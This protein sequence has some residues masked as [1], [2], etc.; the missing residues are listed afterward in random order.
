MP[1]SSVPSAAPV[2]NLRRILPVLLEKFDRTV[3]ISALSVKAACLPGAGCREQRLEAFLD[4]VSC[5]EAEK[6]RLDHLLAVTDDEKGK[7]EEKRAV[8]RVQRKLDRDEEILRH[9]N[10]VEALLAEEEDDSDCG[11]TVL[12][13]FEKSSSSS[14]TR[15]H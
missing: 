4:Y 14:K 9:K 11:D 13:E 7:L 10:R 8:K 6:E 1:P 15:R 2:E 12:V 5:L 3:I